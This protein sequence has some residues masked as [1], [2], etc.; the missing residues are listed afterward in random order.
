MGNKDDLE[1]M[2]GPRTAADDDL[3]GLLAQGRALVKEVWRIS[4]GLAEALVFF[5]DRPEHADDLYRSAIDIDASSKIAELARGRLSEI[6]Q[7]IFRSKTPGGERIDAVMYLVGA[8]ET[9][10]RMSKRG[11]LTRC[12]PVSVPWTVISK[13]ST[14]PRCGRSSCDKILSQMLLF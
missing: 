13:P 8:I 12:V 11:G 10:G 4:S 7:K 14:K 5:H 9:F 1:D 2:A 3:V 6:A